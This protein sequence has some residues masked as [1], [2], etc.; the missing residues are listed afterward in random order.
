MQGVLV[1]CK[2]RGWSSRD[3]VNRVQ[4]LVRPVKVGHAGT[5]D[6]LAEGVLVACLG[7]ATR[8]IEQVQRQ[9][10]RYV[11]QF[12]LGVRSASDDCETELVPVPDSPRPVL[13]DLVAACRASLGEIVQ[14]PPTYSAVK[15][16]G[17]RAYRL[18]RAGVDF[19]PSPRRVRIDELAVEA[20]DYPRLRL[21]ICCGSG[22][23]VRSLGRDLAQA[24]GT[25]AVMVGLTRIAIGPFRIEEAV[26]CRA[27]TPEVLA[28]RILP[29]AAAIGDL[30]RR[31]V[32]AAELAL[33]R[34]G[35]PLAD[36]PGEPVGATLW[37][38]VT[39]AGDLAALLERR[40]DGRWIPSR[41]FSQAL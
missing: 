16:G 33:L 27:L 5:L 25:S 9:P 23:Y 19:Q 6:P 10:K 36:P 18:A 29:P 4:R 14:R 17:R 12:E 28:E 13:A 32:D 41:N 22:A 30:P 1:L 26:D 8:L 37:A 3:A 21:A 24:V 40:E 38:A 35:R 2:P 15:I 31:T 11:A 34:C 20:Y 7:S 39:A